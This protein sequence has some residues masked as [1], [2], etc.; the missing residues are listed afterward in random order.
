MN[1]KVLDDIRNNGMLS[2]LIR[3]FWFYFA[4]TPKANEMWRQ[5][6]YQETNELTN[7]A[8]FRGVEWLEDIHQV[9]F[10]LRR[11]NR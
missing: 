11:F 6:L 7:G 1:E 8:I 3:G 4:V 10:T 9:D 5:Y 2:L